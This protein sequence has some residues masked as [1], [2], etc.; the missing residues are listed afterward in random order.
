MVALSLAYEAKGV[1]ESIRGFVSLSSTRSKCAGSFLL[2][3]AKSM[4]LRN[5]RILPRVPGG[6]CADIGA[7][8]HQFDLAPAAR[9]S[10][11]SSMCLGPSDSCECEQDGSGGEREK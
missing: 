8:F 2:I 1:F 9:K 4:F 3:A 7:L 5:S 6:P 10:S 11:V